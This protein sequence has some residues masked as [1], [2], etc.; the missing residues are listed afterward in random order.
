MDTSATFLDILTVIFFFALM[1]YI[2][3]WLLLI[4]PIVYA[5]KKLTGTERL[6]WILLIIFAS[7]IGAAVFWGVRPYRKSHVKKA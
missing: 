4:K 5:V 7:P 6:A 3:I 2:F 1:L